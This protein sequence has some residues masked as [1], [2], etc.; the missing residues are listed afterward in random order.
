MECILLKISIVIY[1]ENFS[2]PPPPQIKDRQ[3]DP[4]GRDSDR[5]SSCVQ[6]VG[7]QLGLRI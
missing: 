3:N 7:N 4:V 5:T 1:I 2:A 6:I